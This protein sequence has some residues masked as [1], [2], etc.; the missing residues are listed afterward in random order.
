MDRPAALGTR[1][2]EEAAAAGAAAADVF[3]KFSRAR[4]MT[5]PEGSVG[6]SLE[7][8]V[9]LRVFM[10]D[11]RSALA[12]TTLTRG[13]DRQTG[14]PSRERA[15]VPIRSLTRR[16]V[17]AA[18]NGAPGSLIALPRSEG[19]NG[20]GLGLLDPDVEGPSETLLEIA[21]QIYGLASGLSPNCAASV[22]LQTVASSVHLYNS[23]GFEGSFRQTLARLD[24]TLSG[25]HEGR[26]AATRVVRASRSLRGL[27]ADLAVADAAS[28][29]EERM[30]PRLPPSGIHTI[31]LAPRAAAEILAA[32]AG[33]LSQGRW[34]EELESGWGAGPRRGARVASAAISL[35]DDGRLPGGVA[36][37]P[38][39]GEGTRTRRTVL[40][41]RG[42][43][44]EILRDLRAGSGGGGSTGN[45]I[46][47]S[48]RDAPELRPTNL[49]VNPGHQ[50]PGD[51]IG[52]VSQG[53]RIST[54]G[55]L[56]PLKSL[57]TPFTVP[58]TG[59]WIHNGRPGTPLGGGY[60]AG[61]LKEILQQIEAAAADLTFFHRRGSYGVPTLLVKRAPVRS[62]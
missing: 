15:A 56:P 22:R 33:W 13:A 37:S 20:R 43:L 8:G 6:H 53:I 44:R 36:S 58:F 52:S 48:F 18:T 35:T 29:L 49:F 11:G 62:I 28:L 55:R 17:A 10:P 3:M 51:L 42:V 12:A 34:D 19:G 7:R 25:A 31:L 61:N 24:L 59:R 23:A 32:V 46:R 60:L 26:H 57:E 54:L 16:A 9:A 47:A 1:L 39:D 2:L 50:Q 14:T 27:A 41:E 30:A 40:I 4:E 45:G 38:F 21:D 5:M